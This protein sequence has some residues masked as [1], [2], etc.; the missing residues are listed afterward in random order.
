MAVTLDQPVPDFTAQA[1]SGETVSLAQ[2]RGRKVVLYFYPKDSTPGCTTQG[3]GFRDMQ[4][5]FQAAGTVVFGVSRDGLKSHENFK[6]KQGFTFEL[7]SDK[8]ETLC[9]LFDVIK[10]KK[11]YG[12]EYLGVD[13]ST[14]LIDEQGVLRRA[15]RGVKVPGHVAEVLEAAQGL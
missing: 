6:A 12:K 13:R 15:W 10:L 3:Q 8:D 14:F 9:Q 7:I 5:Q 4:A 1:T 11:L 2:L